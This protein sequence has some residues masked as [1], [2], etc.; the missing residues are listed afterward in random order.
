[1]IVAKWNGPNDQQL[2]NGEDKKSWGEMK[3]YEYPIKENTR[4]SVLLEWI[5]C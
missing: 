1:M 2:Q 5:L 3:S 4:Y